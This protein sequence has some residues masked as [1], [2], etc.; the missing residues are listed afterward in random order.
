MSN[1]IYFS[2][3]VIGVLCTFFIEDILKL[4]NLPL[5]NPGKCPKIAIV[6]CACPTIL[7]NESLYYNDV[8]S[9]IMSL[10]FICLTNAVLELI[11]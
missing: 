10:R 6:V 3:D 11:T 7:L 9:F 4:G 5:F 1:I 8:T 2:I